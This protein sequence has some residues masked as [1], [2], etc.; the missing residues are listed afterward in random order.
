MAHAPQQEVLRQAWLEGRCGNLSAW[1]EAKLWAV[2]EV[3]RTLKGGEW[4][5]QSFAAELVTK[6]GTD[7]H[8]SQA[9]VSLFYQ[10]IDADVDWFPGKSYREKH[11]PDKV[12]SIQSTMAIANSAQAMKRRKIEPTYALIVGSCPLAI[13][14][15]QTGLPVDK[16]IVYNIFREYCFD[17]DADE[18]W[19]HKARYSKTSLSE[20]MIGRRL[21]FGKFVQD[22]GHTESWYFMNIIW[23]DI[24]NSI[25]PR[26]EQKASEQSLARKGKRGWISPGCEFDSQNLSGN[27]ESEKQN[28][29]GTIKIWW[30]PVLTRGKLHVEVFD[31]TFPGEN[32]RGASV[33]VAKVR[34]A[35][36]VRF[37]SDPTP[38][39]TLWTDRGKGFYA[40]SNGKITPEFK[41]ALSDHQFKAIFNDDASIQ[42]GR[43]QEIML[44]ET[45]IAWIRLRLAKSVPK[46]PWEETREEYTARLKA[47]V[48]DIN[49]H[50]NVDGLC[51]ALP[52]RINTLVDRQ[53]D[54]LKW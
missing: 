32:P 13:M 52:H 37:Q 42:P 18:P 38:P 11:G 19:S 29:W 47:C 46:N 27:K 9:A 4:G 44:H 23:T 16:K 48:A 51:R 35:V 49:L 22:V 54:R 41:Q 31:D 6:A 7:E 50:L 40:T 1:S 43:L 8:P 53:G 28:S 34:A 45:A 36:N 20:K 17:E 15:P 26:S 5:L 21:V 25:L 10:K 3:W 12:L 30:A 14:N 2:R 24:C 39:R 33:L